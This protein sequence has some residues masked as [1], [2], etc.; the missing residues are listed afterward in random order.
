MLTVG[1]TFSCSDYKQSKYVARI[2]KNI[3]EFDSVT[4]TLIE[5]YSSHSL[6][7]IIVVY[8]SEQSIY[9]NDS[10]VFDTLLIIFVINTILHTF[11]FINEM[12]DIPI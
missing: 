12:M 5:K 9:S 1:S 3:T 2:K 8:P 6:G 11:K 10:R 7:S 4:A